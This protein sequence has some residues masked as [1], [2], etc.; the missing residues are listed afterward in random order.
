[1]SRIKQTSFTEAKS[2]PELR[3]LYLDS[4]MPQCPESVEALVYDDDRS[5]VSSF[6]DILL[7]EGYM[8]IKWRRIIT[9][10]IENFMEPPYSMVVCPSTLLGRERKQPIFVTEM[11][12]DE[13]ETE[14]Y[15]LSRILDHETYHADDAMYG[16]RLHDGLLIDHT[17][18]SGF[19]P[20]TLACLMEIRAYGNQLRNLNKRNISDENFRGDIVSELESYE[21]QLSQVKPKS[22][23]ESKVMGYFTK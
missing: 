4:I 5:K 21:Y 2:N 11:S 23:L 15:L 6:S 14:S 13:T 10:D 19:S 3:Q 9:K 22:K 7:S 8:D 18:E 16:L 1:M 12:F 20:I 17:N